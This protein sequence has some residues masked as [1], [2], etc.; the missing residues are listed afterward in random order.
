L[1][2]SLVASSYLFGSSS[3]AK[4]VVSLGRPPKICEDGLAT[5]SSFSLSDL[6]SFSLSDSIFSSLLFDVVVVSSSL[7]DAEEGINSGTHAYAI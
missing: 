2:A 6:I 4:E 7:A 3:T 5:F 1:T